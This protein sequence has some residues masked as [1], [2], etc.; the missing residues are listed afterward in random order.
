MARVMRRSSSE[1]ERRQGREMK[2]EREAYCSRSSRRVGGEEGEGE[3][4]D[5]GFWYKILDISSAI[6]AM[7]RRRA[8]A[9]GR[10]WS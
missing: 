5:L 2:G 6:A 4:E 3:G 9:S 10:E 1:G 8:T 7:L